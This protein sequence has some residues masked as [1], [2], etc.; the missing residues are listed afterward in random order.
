MSLTAVVTSETTIIYNT[1]HKFL[2]P[3]VEILY[4]YFNAPK[5]SLTPN[6]TA[7]TNQTISSLVDNDEK[8]SFFQNYSLLFYHKIVINLFLLSQCHKLSSHI[9]YDPQNIF[10]QGCEILAHRLFVE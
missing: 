1:N 4:H 6:L 3:I 10:Y 8:S 2:P 5:V 9:N 7:K